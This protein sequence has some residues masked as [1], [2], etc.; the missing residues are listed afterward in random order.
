MTQEVKEICTIDG[1]KGLLFCCKGLTESLA[2]AFLYL[3]DDAKNNKT[4]NSLFSRVHAILYKRLSSARTHARTHTNTHT[5]THAHANT[6][7]YTR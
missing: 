7:I 6:R 5:H 3:I 4:T 1:S 2:G